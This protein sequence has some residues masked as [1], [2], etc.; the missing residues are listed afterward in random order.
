MVARLRF[1]SGWL[2]RSTATNFHSRYAS[3][4]NI[5]DSSRLFL[6]GRVDLRQL[7]VQNTIAHTSRD[8]VLV[9]IV[10]QE[11]RLLEAAVRELVAD[12]VAL[13][14]LLLLAIALALFLVR[15]VVVVLAL[16]LL[17]QQD[18]QLVL[19]VD[20]DGK[21]VLRHTRSGDLNMVS[22]VIL[23]D[24]DSRRVVR[25]MYYRPFITE[26]VVK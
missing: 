22:T 7:D 18:Y 12:V 14:F 15:L 20:M 13:G 17:L 26:K 9:Y 6:Y 11:Q 1:H 10:R 3:L 24:I 21:I 23:Q 19:V 4:L 5:N 25:C 8:F 2:Y 16:T